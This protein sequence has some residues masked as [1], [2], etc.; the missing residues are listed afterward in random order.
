[1][2]ATALTNGKLV[3]DLI[4]DTIRKSGRRADVRNLTGS[5]LM[6]ALAA[7][8]QEEASEAANAIGDR[9]K[10]IDELADVAEVVS[11][12]MEVSGINEAEVAQA[13]RDK[14]E[15]CGRFQTGA[16][17]VSAIPA[18][19]RQYT[20]ADVDAQRVKWVP[21]R[22]IG[23]FV[24]HENVHAVL[25]AHSQEAGGI[26]RRFIHDRSDGDP[27]DLFLMAMAWGYQPK[28]YGPARTQ[29]VLASEGAEEK[30]RAIVNATR[31]DGA[32][33]GWHALLNTHKIDGLNMSFGTKLLY[34]AGYT[35]GHR[36]RPLVLDERVRASLNR[37]DVAPGT[38]PA[39]GLV[40]RAD[41]IRYLDLA[42]TWASDPEWKQEPDVV[43][44]ALFAG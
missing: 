40:Y 12:L 11:T 42:E 27:V 9:K 38:V 25:A 19:I 4:P 22:W 36:P 18:L 28:D 3:R 24:G 1:M 37:P 14:A 13:A 43:E 30:I 29:R 23:T 39:R 2:E 8:L 34:F 7:K 21:E 5:E 32:E 35:T 20:R 33:A 15:R 26:A 17:L 16:W 10:L 44:H 41:Y 6:T 31:F